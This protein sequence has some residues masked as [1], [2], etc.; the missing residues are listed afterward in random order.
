MLNVR[1]YENLY[2]PVINKFSNKTLKVELRNSIKWPKTGEL[3]LSI[4][5]YHIKYIQAKNNI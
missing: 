4:K 2:I 1:M 3:T 5:I